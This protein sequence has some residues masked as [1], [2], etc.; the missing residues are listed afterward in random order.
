M[1]RGFTLIE[2]LVVIAIIGILSAT[3]LVSLNQARYKALDA[4]RKS[5]LTQI[6][7][8]LYLYYDKYGNY[9]TD[10]SGC[11][12]SGNGSGWFNNPHLSYPSIGQCLANEGFT[13][14]EIIDPSGAR[15]TNASVQGHI[16]MKYSCV[17]SSG[18]VGGTYIYASLATQPRF[19]D[20]PTNGTCCASCDTLY[21]MNYYRHLAD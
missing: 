12:P 17:S 21:G 3:V 5:D 1:R 4:R 14:S 2:L 18:V 20:G 16:Y 10:G 9:V 7:R 19:V 6:E 13:G 11:G 8:A 15:T